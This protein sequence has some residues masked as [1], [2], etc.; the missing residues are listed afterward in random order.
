LVKKKNLPFFD[1][2]YYDPPYNQH[3]YGSNYFMLNIINKGRPVSIQDGV[4]GIA[5]EWNRSAYNKRK[6]A[7]LA[8]DDLLANTYARFIAI[9][10]N[11]EGIIP[12]KK[13]KEIL[14]KYGNWELIE[15]DYNTYRGSR[16][17]RNRNI[18]VKEFLWILEKFKS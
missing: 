10:Y 13:F 18:K 4:S 7:E 3:P 16:N 15:Q 11:D 5:K 14:S 9:S 1:L 6:E 12:I 2:V 17:L 8:M